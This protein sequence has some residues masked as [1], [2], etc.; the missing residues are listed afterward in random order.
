LKSTWLPTKPI[1]QADEVGLKPRYATIK[2]DQTMGLGHVV[3][4]YQSDLRSVLRKILG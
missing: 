1:S 3:I 2:L 4:H